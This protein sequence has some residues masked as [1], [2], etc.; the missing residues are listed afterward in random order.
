MSQ[1]ALPGII[2]LPSPT[3]SNWRTAPLSEILQMIKDLFTS[4]ALAWI[5]SMDALRAR[6][7]L[8]SSA[9]TGPDKF[10]SLYS[11]GNLNESTKGSYWLAANKVLG[12]RW[13]KSPCGSQSQHLQ[14]LSKSCLSAC[15]RSNGPIYWLWHIPQATWHPLQ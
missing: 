6:K 1:K 10:E 11:H 15:T 4:L 13:H 7:C 9:K 5:G 2:D 14:R 12:S 3:T 8:V